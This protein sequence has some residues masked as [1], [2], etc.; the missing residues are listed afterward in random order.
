MTD[1]N[2]PHDFDIP[3]GGGSS[4]DEWLV[5]QTSRT[6][7]VGGLAKMLLDPTA[8]QKILDFGSKWTQ[9]VLRQAFDEFNEAYEGRTIVGRPMGA[10]VHLAGQRYAERLRNAAA[11]GSM[12]PDLVDE[13]AALLDMVHQLA[14]IAEAVKVDDPDMKRLIDV[15][16]TIAR[17]A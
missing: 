7:D 3:A 13:V 4:W 10:W 8:G 1:S 11:T 12:P 14:P 2:P 15:I 5:L 17:T 9:A 16:L 6:D